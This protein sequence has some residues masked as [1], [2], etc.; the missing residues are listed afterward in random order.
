VNFI[1]QFSAAGGRVG[2][3]VGR[4]GA[5]FERGLDRVLRETPAARRADTV[6][7]ILNS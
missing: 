2:H 7:A 4:D 1:N 5:M 3:T 6:T